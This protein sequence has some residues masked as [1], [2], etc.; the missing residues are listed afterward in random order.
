MIRILTPV[1]LTSL[2][3]A[4]GAS[5]LAQNNLQ[6]AGADDSK[7]GQPMVTIRADGVQQLV[8]AWPETRIG[9]LMADED[10]APAVAA[11]LGHTNSLLARQ[12]AVRAEFAKLD[13]LDGMEPWEIANLYGVGDS[14]IWKLFRF[15]VEEVTRAEMTV[16]VPD[17]DMRM[18]PTFLTYLS[19]SPRYEGR[20]TQ[21]FE[22]EVQEL[23]ASKMFEEVA[24]TKFNGFPAYS[25]KAPKEVTGDEFFDISSYSR[26]ML[27][28]PG[29]FAY[30]SGKP[31]GV[32]MPTVRGKQPEIA[33]DID[34]ASYMAMFNRM[35]M[36]VP[37]EFA[38][39]GFDKLATLKWSGRFQGELIEDRIDVVLSGEPAGAVGVLLTGEA[40]LPA[41]ALPKGAIAQLRAAL[42]LKL[43]PAILEDQQGALEKQILGQISK[44]FTGGVAVSCCAPAPG[45]VIPRIYLS[46]DIADNAVVDAMLKEYLGEDV[47]TKKVTY[48]GVEC[49][50]LKIPDMPNGIQPAFCRVGNTMHIAESALSLR[51]FLK[52]QDEQTV[53]MDVGDAPEPKGKGKRLALEWRFDEAKLYECF[54]R[55]WL[56]L[57]ELTGMANQAPIRKKDLPEPDVVEMYC[58]KARGMLEKDGDTYS[59]VLLGALGGPEVAAVAMTYGPMIATEMNDYQTDQLTMRLARHKLERVHNT[60]EKFKAREKRVPKDLAEWFVA[61]KL[62]DDALLLPADD[63]AESIQL[64]DGRTVKSSFRY[65]PKPVAFRTMT[66]DDGPTILI[67]VRTRSYNRATMT[68]TGLVPDAY[69]PDNQ[70]PIEKFAKGN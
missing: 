11:V 35:G 38:A 22:R 69:G 33:L 52:A 67:E 57:Y 42:N 17:G 55:D 44:A 30:G 13:L 62:A 34:L 27:H 8:K 9:K 68:S 59:L 41:Q 28:M 39:L 14:D 12:R 65:F 7:A 70:K 36:G 29:T 43:L 6:Q 21:A 26:W 46:I 23:R 2:A 45:G 25:F 64:P 56:P 51:A 40:E 20:W 48:Q 10:V 54:Y 63:L 32:E 18:A 19:C 37:A 66:G 31:K 50:V 24:D 53:A 49:T 4:P 60:L 1:L 61:E 3:F 47:P 16:L 15:P 5:L 58:G